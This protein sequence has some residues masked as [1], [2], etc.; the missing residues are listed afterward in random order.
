[1]YIKATIEDPGLIKGVNW[2]GY[3]ICD[4]IYSR[5][6]IFK[7]YIGTIRASRIITFVLFLLLLFLFPSFQR[8]VYLF[9]ESLIVFQQFFRL[10]NDLFIR[11]PSFWTDVLI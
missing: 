5:I 10:F 4:S 7:R 6:S 2:V 11:F 3:G 9:F 1:M 8:F